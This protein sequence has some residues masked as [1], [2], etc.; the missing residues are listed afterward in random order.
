VSEPLGAHPRVADLVVR[1]YLEAR[2]YGI[3]A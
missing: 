2:C 3:A 1:R